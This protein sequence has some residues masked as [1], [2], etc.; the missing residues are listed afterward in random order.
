MPKPPKRQLNVRISAEAF[1]ALE[2]LARDTTQAAVIERLLI[3]S[4]KRQR[5]KEAQTPGQ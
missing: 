1:A 5:R 3:A 2:H 4:A